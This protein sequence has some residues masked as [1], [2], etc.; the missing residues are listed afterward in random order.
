MFETSTPGFG[1]MTA[2]TMTVLSY[3]RN[4]WHVNN[5]GP[6]ITLDAGPNI[7]LLFRQNQIEIKREILK[8]L[9]KRFKILG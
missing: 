6:L 2:D 4:Y 8:E 7:H 5:D 3:I 1:Y 9:K